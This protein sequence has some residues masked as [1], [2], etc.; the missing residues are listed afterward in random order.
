VLVFHFEVSGEF[1][2]L[3]LDCFFVE[4]LGSFAGCGPNCPNAPLS[5][6]IHERMRLTR[7]SGVISLFRQVIIGQGNTQSVM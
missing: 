7:Q 6:I 2:R 1:E 4:K 3:A 5:R